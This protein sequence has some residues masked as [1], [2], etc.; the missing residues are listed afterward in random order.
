MYMLHSLSV[1]KEALLA[2]P[3]FLLFA[4][5]LKRGYTMRTVDKP[6]PSHNVTTMGNFPNA[7]WIS[8]KSS[9]NLQ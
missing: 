8:S 7:Q 2:G 9:T 4:Q 1:C 3:G 5:Q 6:M